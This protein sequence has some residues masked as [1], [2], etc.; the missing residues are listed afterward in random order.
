MHAIEFLRSPASNKLGSAVVL[1]GQERFL[2]LEAIR[3]IASMVVGSTDDDLSISHFNGNG[4]LEWKTVSDAL[5]TPSM[6]SPGQ[7][8]VVDDADTFISNCRPQLEKYVDRPAKKSQLV[9]D[10]K[11]LN[12]ITNLAKRVAVVGLIIEC[13]P[14]KPGVM[15]SWVIDRA[16]QVHQKELERGAAPLL[17]D[18][19]GCEF[20]S[21]DQELAKLTAFAGNH[22]TITIESVEK[23]VGGWKMETTWVMTNAIQSGDYEQALY[24]LDKLLVAGETPIKLLGGVSYVFKPAG[25]SQELV[26]R[27]M[28]PF[29]AVVACGAKQFSAGDLVRYINRVGKPRC[30]RIVS[31]L[32]E[33]DQDLKGFGAALPDRVIL[34]RL[35]FRLSAPRTAARSR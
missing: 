5:L 8:I 21:L 29:D 13:S 30:E 19:I 25:L 32:L 1:V 7:L 9:L 23:L 4:E 12:S 22:P 28:S 2:K 10:C 14:I 31:W 18:L 20:G 15:T 27:G 34:E 17:V 11:A 24:L 35:F 3:E 33:A 26:R 16:R 6:W